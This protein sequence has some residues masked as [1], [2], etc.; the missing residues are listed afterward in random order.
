[1]EDLCKQRTHGVGQ[2]AWSLC[3]RSG[4]WQQFQY[5]HSI[6]FLNKKPTQTLENQHWSPGISL[7]VPFYLKKSSLSWE[8]RA[9]LSS[10]LER[11]WAFRGLPETRTFLLWPEKRNAGE[12]GKVWLLWQ[13]DKAGQNLYSL[14]FTTRRVPV[15][16]TT[17]KFPALTQPFTQQQ[18]PLTLMPLT[19]KATWIEQ[20]LPIKT[21]CLKPRIICLHHKPILGMN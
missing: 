9:Q 13:N 5:S 3:Q 16:S 6:A 2:R 8:R 14:D 17:L 11:P 4:L 7:T 15:P 12:L 19:A 20:L 1:M 10:A 21:I 18:N